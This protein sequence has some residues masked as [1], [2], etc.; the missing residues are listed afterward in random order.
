MMKRLLLVGLT[1]LFVSKANA[2]CKGLTLTSNKTK[3][4]APGL[5]EFKVTGA[6]TGS[7]YLWDVGQGKIGGVD[8]IYGFYSQAQIVNAWVEITFPSGQTCTLTENQIAKVN[9]SPSPS[10]EVSRKLLC[11]GPDSVAFKNTT[12]N[13]KSVS[14]VID[15]TNY[16][17]YG[18]DVQHYYSTPGKKDLY[19]IIIDNNGCR[20]ILNQKA[21]VDVRSDVDVDFIA[22]NT[23]GCV[24]KNVRLKNT[25]R[26]NGERIVSYKW[27]Y[28]GQKNDTSALEHP[29][30]IRYEASGAYDVKLEVTTAKGCVHQISKENYLSFG[31]TTQLNLVLSDSL[32][33][34][35][36]SLT[37]K[38]QDELPGTY[39][40]NMEG[41]TDTLTIGK[42]GVKLTYDTVGKFDLGLWY[43]YNSC[44]SKNIM[45]DKIE[46]N[47]LEV[48]FSS[49]DNFHCKLPHTSHF[50]N[51]TKST[52]SGSIDYTWNYYQHRTTKL[53]GTSKKKNDEYT[54]TDWG[55]YDVQLVA[56]HSNGCSDT[57]KK[58]NYL[59]V[60]SIRPAVYA[61]PR[62]AC[63]DQTIS[64]FNA[65]PQSSYQS[66]DTFYWKFYK[67]DGKTIRSESRGTLIQHSYQDT[68][69]YDIIF[70]AGNTIGCQ[71]SIVLRDFVDIIIPKIDYKVA[72]PIVCV[73]EELRLEANSSPPRANFEYYWELEKSDNSSLIMSDDTAIYEP[74]MPAI[75][76]YKLKYV[77]HLAGG[78]KDSIVSDQIIKINGLTAG[79]IVDSLAGC[80]GMQAKAKLKVVQNMHHG[81]SS[82]IIKYNWK[83]FG[84]YTIEDPH[85]ETPLFTFNV[86]GRPRVFLEAENSTGCVSSFHSDNINIGVKAGMGEFDKA[87]CV[88]QSI[89]IKAI[90]NS[91]ATS[92]KWEIFPKDFKATIKPNDSGISLSA[93][94]S[95]D[96]KIRLIASRYSQCSDTV[97]YEIDAQQVI[98]DFVAADTNLFCAPVYAQ[99]E[100]RSTG[101]DSFIW[102]FGEGTQIAT[103]DRQIANIYNKNSGWSKGYDIQLISKNRL[104]CA[105]TLTK[106]GLVKVLG[107]VPKFELVNHYGC[108][109]LEVSFVDK[110][111][112]VYTYHMDYRDGTSLDSNGL[113]THTYTI[114]NSGDRQSYRPALYA[115]DSL[116]CVATYESDE[117]VSVLRKPKLDLQVPNPNG[118]VPHSLFF[119]HDTKN[120]SKQSW[121]LNGVEVSDQK[122]GNFLIDSAGVYKFQL[123]VTNNNL[124]SDTAEITVDIHSSP[125][126]EIIT[127][128]EPCLNKV[129]NF[130]LTGDTNF[131]IEHYLWNFDD[132]Q[133]TTRAHRLGKTSNTFTVPGEKEITLT[134]VD[135]YQCS[136]KATKKINIPDPSKIV[137]PMIKQVTVTDDQRILI[138]WFEVT[139]SLMILNKLFKDGFVDANGKPATFF[140]QANNAKL[141]YLDQNA[142]VTKSN[143]YT[144]VNVDRCDFESPSYAPHCPIILHVEKTT[145]SKL[146]LSWTHYKGWLEVEAY[147]IYRS[148]KGQPY[149]LIHTVEGFANEFEDQFL[150]TGE[151]KYYVVGRFKDRRSR[152]N[153]V[154]DFPE[155]V[156]LADRPFVKNVTVLDNG[157]IEVKMNKVENPNWE[158]HILSKYNSDMTQLLDVIETYED[159]YIDED[160]NISNESYV[161]QL[162]EKDRCGEVTLP[163]C[164]GKSILLEG[165][166][167]DDKS[168]LNWNAYEKWENGVE[169]YQLQIRD[170]GEFKDVA[171]LA[172]SQLVYHDGDPHT[173]I[174]DQHCYRVMAISRNADGD[175]S[176]SN[177]LCTVGPS[178]VWVPNA[179]TPNDDGKND[180]FKPVGQFLKDWDDGS[181]REYSMKIYSSWGQK[182]FE[183][184]DINEA[185]DGTYL[186][187]LMVQDSYFYSI[188]I[189]GVDQKVFRKKGT[190]ILIK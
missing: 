14:W 182:L 102:S 76:E 141:S 42:D 109:P 45:N 173:E 150:C 107:P 135:E 185:W 148:S 62:I 115:K 60:D 120:S 44:L 113:Y 180:V 159:V 2:Q 71:D 84:A 4:C 31:D 186:G 75:G 6:P 63:V 92:S 142:D 97:E 140:E 32:L 134:I 85:N 101:A 145:P 160:A 5:I 127:E 21:V 177:V 17:D 41:A 161:Y 39:F 52:G 100:A 16:S 116:G 11:D 162:A 158:A 167:V 29:N 24:P 70:Y 146:R 106:H 87:I 50:K 163:G 22:D 56:T 181:Y 128:E 46:V 88:G 144:M 30:Q 124:C 23:D 165:E 86:L 96:F 40:W 58:D 156:K 13:A 48:D 105:D 155:F 126:V 125:T 187:D 82:D 78:C 171:E 34:V 121:L 190:V 99:F 65:T 36:E 114:E 118:C 93:Q 68:G 104:G 38:T 151:Y 117:L 20:S 184:T 130:D 103:I 49:A 1:C 80:V 51:L 74:V 28:E 72:D 43:S 54:N 18:D 89:G 108:D 8:T 27:K 176:F 157:T 112:D 25:S 143:C 33:C 7:S 189:S 67:K 12:K 55:V 174:H 138:E 172:P 122:S 95:G 90:S 3:I 123:A 154:S 166:Y 129:V 91:V 98:S 139:D 61:R 152:S 37:I 69:L 133:A 64:F 26:L 170:R 73:G 59:R 168:I 57:L 119:N 94:E 132:G 136:F 169:K 153:S 178:Q 137:M 77:H 164:T 9:G 188:E 175:T 179:F 66:Q 110:S 83:A 147:D 53:I 15:G 10:F 111:T 131:N 35:G 149:E 79:I 19:L 47:S 81:A 183:T